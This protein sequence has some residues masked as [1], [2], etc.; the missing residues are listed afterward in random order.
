VFVF[1]GCLS[2]VKKCT[3]LIIVLGFALYKNNNQKVVEEQAVCRGT[4]CSVKISLANVKVPAICKA[5]QYPNVIKF[6][7]GKLR[8]V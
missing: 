4:N 5:Q 2:R 1:R 7:E 6:L 3:T 8:S